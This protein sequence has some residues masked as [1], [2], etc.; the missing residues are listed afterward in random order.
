MKTT[1]AF[2]ITF[3]MLISGLY[4]K[5]SLVFPL[6]A[7]LLVFSLVALRKGHSLKNVFIYILNGSRKSL[8]IVA[9]FALIAAVIPLW[10]AGGTIPLIVYYSIKIINPGLFLLSAFIISCAVSFLLGTAFG[11]TGT[12]GIVLIV[13]AR[14]GN[15]DIDMAAGAIIAGAF[16]GDRTSPMS[17]SA[18]L[19]ARVTETDLYVNVRNMLKTSIIPFFLSAAAYLWLSSEYPLSYGGKGIEEELS[20]LFNLNPVVIIPAALILTLALFRLDIRLSMSV[21]ILS[22]LVLAIT[23]QHETLNDIFRYI[24]YGFP[25]KSGGILG[26]TI[27][28]G[29]MLS[30]VN[31]SMIV[32]VSSAYSGIFEG[33]GMLDEVLVF[34]DKFGSKYGLYAIT[35]ATSIVTAC[36]GCTQALAVILT[37]HLVRN[38]YDKTH[39]GNQKLALDLEDTAIVIS[40]LIPWNIAGAVPASILSAGPGFILYAFFLYLLPATGLINEYIARRKAAAQ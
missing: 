32:L 18:N 6:I 30:M 17:S 19:V 35:I 36:F 22:A 27:N 33:T 1:F 37:C 29:G 24:I 13:I 40:P 14:S 34:I 4:L 26:S 25:S 11:T 15:I 8:I 31:V 16:F 5:I 7:G 21:S 28:G 39:T 3:L 9:I 12:I 38:T 10:M 2:I 20:G 23:L